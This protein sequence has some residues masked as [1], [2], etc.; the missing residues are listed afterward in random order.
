MACQHG[1]ENLFPVIR[2]ACLFVYY[3]A[4]HGHEPDKIFMSTEED[5]SVQLHVNA[6]HIILCYVYLLRKSV[7]PHRTASVL[8]TKHL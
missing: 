5:S 3:E 8:V 4:P 2:L 7:S 6:L 1:M